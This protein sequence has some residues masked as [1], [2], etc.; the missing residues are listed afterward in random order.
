M[1]LIG[2]ARLL[3]RI[4]H[5]LSFGSILA[6]G[7]AVLL[8]MIVIVADVVSR[9]VFNV[10]LQG[11]IEVVRVLMIIAVFGGMSYTALDNS[12]VRVEYR[13]G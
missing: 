5:P 3:K 4:L 6:S 13:F 9:N 10:S 12:H 11:A 1:R 7:A 2:F 8:M